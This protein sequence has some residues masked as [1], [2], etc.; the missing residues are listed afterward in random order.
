MAC[1][2]PSPFNFL[3]VDLDTPPLNVLGGGLGG[4]AVAFALAM[5]AASN[6]RRTTVTETGQARAGDPTRYSRE[7]KSAGE[8]I[9]CQRATILP[10]ETAMRSAQF[11]LLW[12]IV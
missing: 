3:C 4:G 5:A 11:K 9:G 2:R 8:N 6:G 7:F 1:R 10:K 12:R